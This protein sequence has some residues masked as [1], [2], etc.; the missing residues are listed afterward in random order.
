MFSKLE[1]RPP[2]P[3]PIRAC[4]EHSCC[5]R[6]YESVLNLSLAGQEA[7]GTRSEW[8]GP[9]LPWGILCPLTE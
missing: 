7:G 3:P 5:A 4:C 8:F 6:W 2:P 1:L 9:S